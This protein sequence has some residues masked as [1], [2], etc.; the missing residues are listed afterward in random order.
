M[1]TPYVTL[2]QAAE[3]FRVSPST[4]RSWVRTGAVPKTSYLRQASVYRFDI[5]AVE[6]A[7][8]NNADGKNETTGDKE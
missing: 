8:R 6:A 1:S 5:T 2:E 7:L 4:F 3:H